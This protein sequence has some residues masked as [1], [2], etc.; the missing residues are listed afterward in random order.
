[1][2]TRLV[3]G[4]TDLTLSEVSLYANLALDFVQTR[5][6]GRSEEALA[7]SSTTSGEN[8][9]AVPTDFGFPI[10]VSNLSV[11]AGDSRTRLW[12]PVDADLFDSRSTT[13]GIPEQYAVYST[14]MEL[15]PSP[16]SSYSIQ[17]RYG[18]KVN[19][20]VASTATPVLDQKFHLAWAYKAAEITASMRQD[21][22]S[23]ALNRARF[24]SEL[25]SLPDDQ[26]MRQRDKLGMRVQ[27]L[28]EQPR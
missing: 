16:D 21:S 28:R 3:Q 17:L 7:I 6:R 14:W 4:R 19:T 12:G 25:G 23:E 9:I 11:T 8:K 2:A 26:A 27:F 5:Q 13:L 1:M 15:W 10:A 24:L 18:T 20:L 22:E